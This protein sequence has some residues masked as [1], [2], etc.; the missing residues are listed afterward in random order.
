MKVTV[1]T[2]VYNTKPYLEQCISSV[3]SQTHADF[4]YLLVDNGSTDGS[5]G[6]LDAF[7]QKDSRIRL[8][9]LE[10][11]R[12][13]RLRDEISR[14]YASGDYYTVL[15]SDDWWE[16]D[17]LERLIAFLEQNDLDLAI[18]GT[19]NYIEA[20]R[21]HTLL[22]K[23]E[24]P[25]VLTLPQFAQ[26]YPSLWVY[27]STVW[28]S[29]MKTELML[30]T[31]TASIT[32]QKYPYGGDTMVMLKYLALCRKIGIEHSAL[33]HYRIHQ[34]SVTYQYNPRRF[35]ANIAL[36]D[37]ISRFLTRYG[38]LNA[39]VQEWLY[40]VHLSSMNTTLDLLKEAARIACHPLTAPARSIT[41]DAEKQWTARMNELA[42][43]ALAAGEITDASALR[44]L[45]S[46]LSPHCAPAVQRETLALFAREDGLRT[47]LLRDDWDSMIEQVMNLIVGRKYSKQFDLGGLLHSLI[48]ECSPLHI[49]E[50]TRF[51]REYP[52]LCL[53][54]L[55]EG[56]LAAL[57]QMTDLL[58][59]EKK[60]YD[61]ERFLTLYLTLAALEH[62]EPAFL[63]GKLK[64]ADF[65]LSQNQR[66]DCLVQLSDLD[67]MGLAG[68]Q[69]VQALRQRLEGAAS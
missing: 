49:I 34:K 51:F 38:A 64:L 15:D 58:L 18:T 61:R 23:L 21:T 29:L 57:G 16:P 50:D 60:L 67:E 37:Q 59:T 26:R 40:R 19:Y 1:Y 69:E 7:A 41:C 14:Q 39:P 63:F 13:G 6:I 55:S 56:T 32:A 53:L 30:Q 43:G 36:Y 33:Y 27:P 46:V 9:R 52:D 2:Q 11:N 28:A 3:L 5:A 4:E 10:E 62:Q 47:A 24:Q 8:I 42:A 48:P 22:R 20:S 54:I 25:V 44:R 45:L 65:Y 35:D 31:D 68:H 17:Y 66:D 12:V